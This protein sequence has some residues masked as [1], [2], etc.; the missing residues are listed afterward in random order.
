MLTIL[1]GLAEFERTLIRARTGERRERAKAQGVRFGR[2]NE[3][4]AD[5]WREVIERVSAG[6]AVAEVAR[7]FGGGPLNVYRLKSNAKLE[8]RAGPCRL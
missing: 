8:L 6:E 5:Q 1:G 4:T 2:P 3:R 7:A